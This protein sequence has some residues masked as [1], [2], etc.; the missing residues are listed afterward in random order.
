MII[1][2]SSPNKNVTENNISILF[3]SAKSL[4]DD[5]IL[6][7]SKDLKKFKK[8]RVDLVVASGLND[9][10]KAKRLGFKKVVS[11]V[12]GI[13][14]EESY[15]RHKS[16][17]RFCF[18]SYLEKKAL[19]KIDYFLFVSEAMRKHYE[20]KYNLFFPSYMVFPCFN[21]DIN[22]D[23]F[24]TPG[25]YENNT[26]VYAGGTA[27]WQNL[28][29]IVEAYSLVESHISNAKFLFL[30]NDSKYA[31]TLV[32]KYGIKNF[33]I[34]Y[35]KKEL[36]PSVLSQ[37]KFGFVLRD[38]IA[39]NNVSTP[40]KLSTYLSCGII[41]VFSNSIHDFFE[42]MKDKKYRIIFNKESFCDDVRSF[43]NVNSD[44]IANEYSFIFDNY[45]S[46]SAYVKIIAEKL[47]TLL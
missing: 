7:D 31:E 3:E 14:P 5:A 37:A 2:L 15:L 39:I 21:T 32:N 19:K 26:F 8:K 47:R 24:K 9:A 28:D 17:L 13:L 45:Y 29:S 4:C 11:W 42:L 46:N 34:K 6:I 20:I 1:V 27:K 35:V 10:L 12:Q 36:L 43:A 25:K 30:T 40:T 23:A 44:E 41:P 38:D 33:E 18:L 22:L 16:K